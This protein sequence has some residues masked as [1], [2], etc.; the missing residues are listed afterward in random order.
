MDA[1]LP[2]PEANPDDT[3]RLRLALRAYGKAIAAPGDA[4]AAAKLAPFAPDD[5]RAEVR[6]RIAGASS[7]PDGL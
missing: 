7:N 2:R 6:A 4:D 3:A 5:V 1:S